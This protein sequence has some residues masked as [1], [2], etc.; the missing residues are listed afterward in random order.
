WINHYLNPL[1]VPFDGAG[2]MG[3]RRQTE[4]DVVVAHWIANDHIKGPMGDA[5]IPPTSTFV[6]HRRESSICGFNV[7]IELIFGHH[8]LHNVAGW[9]PAPRITPRRQMDQAMPR[10]NRWLR[11]R[12]RRRAVRG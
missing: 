1:I 3:T 4:G 8:S 12:S 11:C 2:Q 9:K 10:G 6:A 5:V 7:V